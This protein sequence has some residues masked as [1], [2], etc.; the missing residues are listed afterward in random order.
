MLG[1]FGAWRRR[2]EANLVLACFVC[3]L[4]DDGP[5]TSSPV[6]ERGHDDVEVG[7]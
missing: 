7:E 1:A 6:S 5:I 2:Y 4:S 3:V